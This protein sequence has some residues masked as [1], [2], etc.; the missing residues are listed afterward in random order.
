[1]GRSLVENSDTARA[2]YEQADRILGWDLSRISFEGPE[3]ELTETRVCQPALYVMGYAVF[4]LLRE[5][6]QL[7]DLSLAAG[8]SLGELTALA[9]AEAFSFEDGL[10]VVAER[11]RLMQEACEATHGAMAS[12]I[13]GEVEAVKALCEA[14]DVDMANIN[15][16]GQIVISGE[17]EKV[18]QA[19][20]AA[21]SAG[22]F[23]MV[24]PLKVAGAY[25]SRLMEPARE[26]FE[27]FLEGMPIAEPRLTVLSNT[28]GKAVSSPDEIRTA[29]T[30]QVVS[31]VLW[32][33]CLREAASRGVTELYEC[34][35]GA[36]LAGMARRTDRSLKVACVAEF[37]D[38]D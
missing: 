28:T 13:G 2:L 9:A 15:C 31:S 36:V 22:G 32:E 20:E 8:L 23:R 7:E 30:R 10:R 35:P 17:S 34:G 18:A 24:V 12:L 3:S 38:L 33:D 25:H 37:A 11:G 14:H 5:R 1:M 26:R 6:G 21:K 27:A 19:V 16:P 29:L 4:Q